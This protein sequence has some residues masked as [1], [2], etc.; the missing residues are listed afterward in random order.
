MNQL[1][2]AGFMEWGASGLPTPSSVI[3]S[4]I[5]SLEALCWQAR[6]AIALP[7]AIGEET[8]LQRHLDCF[9]FTL[10]VSTSASASKPFTAASEH[11]RH[12]STDEGA[13]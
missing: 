8:F 12:Y 4:T 7:D 5:L 10:L 3:L 11:G 2:S 9:S 13:L 6:I 1:L